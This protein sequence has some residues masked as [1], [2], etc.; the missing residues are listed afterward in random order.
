MSLSTERLRIEPL[1][2]GDAG[3]L[4]PLLDDPE[5]GRFTGELPPDDVDALRAR[6]ER[7]ERRRSPDGTE[8]WLNWVVRLRADGRAIGVLQ[9]TVADGGTAIAWTIGTAFQ[10][11]GFATEAGRSLLP[12]L[13]ATIG[14]ATIVAWIHP[15]HTASQ[16]VARRIG[17]RPSDRVRGGE[18]AWEDA[19]SG[20]EP[21]AGRRS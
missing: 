17:M 2:V 3:D 11:Q 18:I 13:R 9:A 5:L 10:R 21:R 16:A 19:S 15:D 7:W 14:E 6:F 1:T 8:L 4:F 12:W 20:H